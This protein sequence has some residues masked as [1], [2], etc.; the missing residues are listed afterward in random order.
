MHNI[1]ML[2][3][4]KFLAITPLAAADWRKYCDEPTVLDLEKITLTMQSLMDT[5]PALVAKQEIGKSVLGSPIFAYELFAQSSPPLDMVT[6]SLLLSGLKGKEPDA[7]CTSI[8]FVG[9]LLEDFNAGSNIA[10]YLLKTRKLSFIPVLNPDAYTG[11]GTVK[12]AAKTCKTDESKNGVDLSRNFDSPKWA[13]ASADPCS[14]SYNGPSA[15]SEPETI[16]LRDLVKSKKFVA[17]LNLENESDGD[18]LTYPFN[19]NATQRMAV[20]HEVY[21][22][23]LQTVMKFEKSGP[24]SRTKD[25]TTVGEI[26][27]W[28]YLKASVLAGSLGVENSEKETLDKNFF[29]IRYWLYK[30]GSEIL[31]RGV[32]R[33]QSSVRFKSTGLAAATPSGSLK[34]VVDYPCKQCGAT[35][36]QLVDSKY[37]VYDWSKTAVPSYRWSSSINWPTCHDSSKPA[38]YVAGHVCTVEFGLICKCWTLR[39]GFDVVPYGVITNFNEFP[40]IC[41]A[42]GVTAFKPSHVGDDLQ[43]TQ[44][45]SK[46][47]RGASKKASADDDESYSAGSF[48]MP[49]LV[50]SGLAGL[51]VFLKRNMYSSDMKDQ[52]ANLPDINM[53][54]AAE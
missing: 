18:F 46:I 48:V 16:A 51:A 8:F 34:L 14:L 12:N 7:I 45:R 17:A 47:P 41:R 52:P 37:R 15:F 6:N 36:C 21:F 31:T 10:V 38:S 13:P 4:I 35:P 20:P 24:T 22:D 2:S 33:S 28:L 19:W 50:F 3:Y 32:D 30:S 40:E 44:E 54:P 27:D 1:Q 49:V 39:S 11:S 53:I 9:S 25:I 23:A 26:S 42:G 43:Q 5:Y 29:R